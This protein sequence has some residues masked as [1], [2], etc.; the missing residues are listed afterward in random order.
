[1]LRSVSFFRSRLF[2]GIFSY[3]FC[4]YLLA[5]LTNDIM[6]AWIGYI[7]WTG[8]LLGV[9]GAVS[10]SAW[11]RI[12]MRM[13][14][15]LISFITLIAAKWNRKKI[16]ILYFI[17]QR[18]GSLIILAGG[19]RVDCASYLR[20]W[21]LGG[22]LLKA[23]LAPFHFW[24]VALI[25]CLRNRHNI[26]FQTWQKIVPI[27]LIL[28]TTT[29]S[30]LILII[31]LNVIVASVCRIGR[32]DVF[33]LLFFSGLM[34]TGWLFSRPQNLIGIYFLIYCLICAPVFIIDPRS[35]RLPYLMLNIGGLPPITGFLLKLIVIQRIRFGLRRILLILSLVILFAYLR[36]FL[37]APAS[38]GDLR[39]ITVVVCSFGVLF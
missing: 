25:P 27:F 5:W 11:P 31:L 1:M 8:V 22:L 36:V 30:T 2:R 29:K 16:A 39:A 37:I 24:G 10:A 28:V 14:I 32:K 18:V 35:I 26:T 34:H 38:K 17:M 19:V 3:F 13:E 15:N 6:G 20:K 9:V 12:W 23:S 33:I 4:F 7:M 21:V